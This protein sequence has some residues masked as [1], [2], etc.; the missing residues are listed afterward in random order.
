MK[1]TSNVLYAQK[2]C[3]AGDWED[4]LSQCAKTCFLH[5]LAGMCNYSNRT[6]TVENCHAWSILYSNRRNIFLVGLPALI[7]S[8]NVFYA[9]ERACMKKEMEEELARS[10]EQNR[11]EMANME[12]SWQQRLQESE[13]KIKIVRWTMLYRITVVTFT[14]TEGKRRTKERRSS[15]DYPTLLEPQWRPSADQHDHAFLSPRQE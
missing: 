7:I 9:T 6:I 3:V 15:Q 2:H 4:I 1:V 5:S 11:Q 10:L 8:R 12:M 13:Q 14:I